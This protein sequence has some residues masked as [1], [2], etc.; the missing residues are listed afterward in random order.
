MLLQRYRLSTAALLARDL[1]S[2]ANVGGA[3]HSASTQKSQAGHCAKVAEVFQHCC[4]YFSAVVGSS[5]ETNRTCFA[6]IERP[7]APKLE[8]SPLPKHRDTQAQRDKRLTPSS[9]VC[10]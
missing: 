10:L 4:H 3:D 9:M 6:E 2:S 7:R 1:P 8:A 5:R